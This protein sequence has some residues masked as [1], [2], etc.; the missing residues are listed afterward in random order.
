MAQALGFAPS[1]YTFRQ[2]EN[3]TTKRIDIATNKLRS[4]LHKRYYLALRMGDYDE[5]KAVMEDIAEFNRK[6]P[7]YM[8]DP[9]SIDKSMSQHMETSAKMHNGIS[10]SPGMRYEIQQHLS[11]YQRGYF[12]DDFDEGEE[13][14]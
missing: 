11:E 13:T 4:K 5:Y 12:D 8:I 1:E 3:A 7:T 9:D 6:H 2:E 14:A 10:I